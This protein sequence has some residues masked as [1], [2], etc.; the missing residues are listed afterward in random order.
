MIKKISVSSF[1][2]ILLLIFSFG[3]NENLIPDKFLKA[4][5]ELANIYAQYNALDDFSPE[6]MPGFKDLDKINQLVERVDFNS[7]KFNLLI[8]QYNLLEDIIFPTALSVINKNPSSVQMVYNKLKNYTGNSPLSILSV[9]KRI[10]RIGLLIERLQNEI[11][12]YKTISRRLDISKQKKEGSSESLS[13][14]KEYLLKEK[15]DLKKFL[16][17]EKENLKKLKEKEKRQV[18]KIDEK[19]KE[20]EDYDKKARKANNIVEKLIYRNFAKVRRL[21]VLGL[22]IPKLN[23]IRAFIYLSQNRIDD[24]NSRIKEIDKNISLI[25]KKEKEILRKK[26]IRGVIIL[27]SAFLLVFILIRLTKNIGHKILTKLESSSISEDRKKRYKT[28]FSVILLA[29]KISLWA[30]AILW[31]LGELGLD[32]KPLLVAAG[33]LSFAVGFGAQSLVKDIISGFFILMEE[34]LAIGDVVDINGK[35][36]TVE[37]ISLR[38]ISVRAFDGTLH[39]IPNGSIS[40]VSNLTYDWARTVLK[41]GVS[42]DADPN[43]VEE[44][45]NRTGKEMYEE[46]EWKRKLLEAPSCLGIDSFGDSAVVYTVISRV[47]AGNQWA[48]A[49]ELRKRLK[50][51]FEKENIEI[52]YPYM[53]V[54]TKKQEN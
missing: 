27:F 22:E 45:I 33:G 30:F 12:R 21:R 18:L 17:V 10:N 49:R 47:K 41:V 40:N 36:G 50:K 44:I 23:T 46:K 14:K 29:V 34:Q 11:N 1:L 4:E 5:E 26:I 15:E 8:K 48:V 39:I 13:S 53:N 37:K 51:N 20:A 9:Q 28:L 35:V 7:R 25:R 24:I 31:V 54:I 43:K 42:Y 6:K 52:P 16:S 3:Q 32:Y 2:L 38:T 19:E